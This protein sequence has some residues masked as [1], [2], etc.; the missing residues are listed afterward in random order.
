MLRRSGGP[1]ETLCVQ[2][3][4]RALFSE[5]IEGRTAFGCPQPSTHV[6][7][8]SGRYLMAKH[9]VLRAIWNDGD[10]DGYV[11]WGGDWVE[12]PERTFKQAYTFMFSMKFQ[13]FVDCHL[14]NLNIW[15]GMSHNI[16]QDPHPNNVWYIN[17]EKVTADCF[18]A[19]PRYEVLPQLGV[20]AN[21]DNGP[22]FDY[23]RVLRVPLPPV[24]DVDSSAR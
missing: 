23:F 2:E 11:K 16:S 20:L 24:A 21:I 3:A 17:I 6:V 10:V 8:M 18:L 13:Y 22:T 9:T 4:V 15:E 1:D 5:C 12:S 14:R 19:L 7:R